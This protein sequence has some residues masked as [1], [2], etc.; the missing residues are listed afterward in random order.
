M[1][2]L[3]DLK[4][5]W[6]NL[7]RL[8]WSALKTLWSEW[9]VAITISRVQASY[10]V[11]ERANLRENCYYKL[12]SLAQTGRR[13]CFSSFGTKLFENKCVFTLIR[14]ILVPVRLTRLHIGNKLCFIL[15]TQSTSFKVSISVFLYFISTNNLTVSNSLHRRRT[16]TPVN[17]VCETAPISLLWSPQW[18]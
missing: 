3:E 6:I 4:D 13:S 18:T 12:T 10:Q 5:V 2:G 11:L 9:T 15:N 7:R 14:W 17:D 16:W 8:R 1:I